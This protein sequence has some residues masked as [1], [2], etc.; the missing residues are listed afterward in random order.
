MY[1]SVTS[2]G[3]Y[4]RDR[5]KGFDWCQSAYSVFAQM[6]NWA[7]G[8]QSSKQAAKVLTLCAWLASA[9]PCVWLHVVKLCLMHWI[10]QR[11]P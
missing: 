11:G 8:V 9:L 7:P 10:V 3:G 2:K 6:R 5:P 1:K 4:P